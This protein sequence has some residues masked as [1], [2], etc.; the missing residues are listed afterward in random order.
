MTFGAKVDVASR[1]FGLTNSVSGI[2]GLKKVK[3]KEEREKEV[4]NEFYALLLIVVCNL[5]TKHRK[6]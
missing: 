5:A 1:T 4:K 6:L 3:K 2:I